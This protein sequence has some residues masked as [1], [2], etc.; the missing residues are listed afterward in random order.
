MSL[1]DDLHRLNV[2][3]LCP[4][5]ADIA[6]ARQLEVDLAEAIK[7]LRYYGEK[8]GDIAAWEFLARIDARNG[9]GHGCEL[10]NC[11][12][13]GPHASHSRRAK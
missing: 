7:R 4:G 5:V 12:G 1:A 8:G 9:N 6:H 13:V 2:G 11:S 3:R 10:V